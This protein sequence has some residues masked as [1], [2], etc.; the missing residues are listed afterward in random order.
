MPIR[1]LFSGPDKLLLCSRRIRANAA[2]KKA[3]EHKPVHIVWKQVH[4]P[5]ALIRALAE[6]IN[7]IAALAPRERED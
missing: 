2:A 3:A 6:N 5:K 7:V 4:D 1:Q